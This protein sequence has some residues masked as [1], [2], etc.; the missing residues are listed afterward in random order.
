MYKTFLFIP[1]L[2]FAAT[3]GCQC[4]HK[5]ILIFMEEYCR[6]YTCYDVILG[7]SYGTAYR[8]LGVYIQMKYCD[9]SQNEPMKL[10]FTNIIELY[11]QFS[12]SLSASLHNILY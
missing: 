11:H 6:S 2:Y 4:F 5:H 12:Q 10:H 7:M 8:P 1:E 3:L 9:K